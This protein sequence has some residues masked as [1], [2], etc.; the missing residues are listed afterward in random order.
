MKHYEIIDDGTAHGG[1]QR[2][3][4][5]AET[6]GI[7]LVIGSGHLR[8]EDYGQPDVLTTV[9]VGLFAEEVDPDREVFPDAE[10][11]SL[12]CALHPPEP[13]CQVGSHYWL[14]SVYTTFQVCRDC[15]LRMTSEHNVVEHSNTGC[16]DLFYT[17]ISYLPSVTP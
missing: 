2:W 6:I 4:V 15:H 12:L 11:D 9:V 17:R 16:G 7:A 3:F 13:S 5:E 8:W 10:E 14:D 1:L